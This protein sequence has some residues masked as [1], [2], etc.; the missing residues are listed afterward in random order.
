MSDKILLKLKR[1]IILAS[2]LAKEGHI[3]S[4]LSVLDLIWVLYDQVLRV[5][6]KRTNDLTM[7]RFILSKG[8]ASLA[9]YSVLAEKGFFPYDEFSSY[10]MYKGMLGGH[11]DST[12]VPGV[13]AS[14]G[15]LGHGFPMAVGMALA[16]KILKIENQI[17]C[18]IGDGE[19]N[20]GAVWEAALLAP[21]QRLFNLSCI[22]DYNHS[23]DRAL[24]I[25][26]LTAKF[27]SFGWDVVEID[28]HDHGQIFDALNYSHP[29]TPLAIIAN[30]IKGKGVW[31]MENEPSWH[32]RA[33]NDD[34]LEDILRE[35]S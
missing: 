15:S 2:H 11:P 20:E 17:F 26:D 4:A 21:H 8:H 6:P 19:C 28:G 35:L 22:V 1:N 29:N 16:S 34:E 7:D 31:R 12:K 30:T 25:G 18:L 9:L 24:K 10:C 33:V 13:E 14:T 27:K 32:H 23:T 5:D 3:P